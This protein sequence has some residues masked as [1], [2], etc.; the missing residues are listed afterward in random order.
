LI[1]QWVKKRL[2]SAIHFQTI[3]SA[4]VTLTLCK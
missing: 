3:P 2:V 1:E 4:N